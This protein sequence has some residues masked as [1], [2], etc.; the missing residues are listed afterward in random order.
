MCIYI[1]IYIYIYIHNALIMVYLF[2]RQLYLLNSNSEVALFK[3]SIASAA[4][5]AAS[6]NNISSSIYGTYHLQYII[7]TDKDIRNS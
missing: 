2:V 1:Y 6:A 7:Q 4:S 5:A 3:Q